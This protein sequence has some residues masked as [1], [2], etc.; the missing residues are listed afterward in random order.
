[1]PRNKVTLILLV[2]KK[3]SLTSPLP[4][5]SMPKAKRRGV[6]DPL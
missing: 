3:I 4:Y 5:L 1:M 2:K 6:L